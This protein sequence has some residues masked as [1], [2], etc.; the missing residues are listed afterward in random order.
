M[1]GESFITGDNHTGWGPP[2]IG[3]TCA[4]WL[5]EEKKINCQAGNV[6]ALSGTAGSISRMLL[7]QNSREKT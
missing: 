1:A 4:Q 6:L 3:R 5:Q 2:K 7:V